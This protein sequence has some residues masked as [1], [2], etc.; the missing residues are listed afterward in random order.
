[1]PQRSRARQQP[2]GTRPEGHKGVTAALQGL[3]TETDSE[4]EAHEELLKKNQE[5][6]S[7]R[8]SANRALQQQLL[9]VLATVAAVA[10]PSRQA[11]SY[12]DDDNERRCS[13]RPPSPLSLPSPKIVPL[14]ATYALLFGSWYHGTNVDLLSVGVDALT[15]NAENLRWIN[16]K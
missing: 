7:I 5:D 3:F 4:D 13:S 14:L 2:P 15:T 8:A 11:T 1:M 10:P 6:N 12:H 9:T 16:E